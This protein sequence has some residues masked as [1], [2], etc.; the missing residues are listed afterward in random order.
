[1][2]P[3]KKAFFYK[4]TFTN[5]DNK[6]IESKSVLA[7]KKDSDLVAKEIIDTW[8]STIRVNIHDYKYELLEELNVDEAIKL[9]SKTG[10]SIINDWRFI[11][12]LEYCTLEVESK[13]I[14]ELN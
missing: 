1:M 14:A 9:K 6:R 8:N 4:S 11:Q 5:W 2:H 10:A 3:F 13:E 7:L 12:H